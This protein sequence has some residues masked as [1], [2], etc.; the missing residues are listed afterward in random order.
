QPVAAIEQTSGLIVGIVRGGYTAQW[1]RRRVPAK[2]IKVYDSNAA[3][4]KAA[5]KGDIK[6]FV[7]TKISLLYYLRQN[8]LANIF[9]HQDDAPL[10]TQIYYAATRKTNAALIGPV[11][12]GLAAIGQEERKA[13]EAKWIVSKAKAISPELA[14]LLSDR[15]LAYLAG[16]EGLRVYN[17]NAWAPFNFNAE[18]TA[19]GF[20]IDYMQLLAEKSG[21]EISFVNG[22]GWQEALE[23]MRSDRLDVM[24]NMARDPQGEA[25][26]TFTAP[27][28]ELIPALYTRNDFPAVTS[29]EDLYGKRLAAA[30]GFFAHDMFEAHPQIEVVP[31]ADTV[32]AARAVSIGQADALVSFMPV[33]DAIIDRIQITNLKVGGDLGIGDGTPIPLRIAVRKT[34]DLLPAILDK[35]MALVSYQESDSLRE[36]WLQ[37]ADGAPREVRLRQEEQD[38]L[39]AHQAI[40][41]GVDPSWPPFELTDA[42]GVYA[43]I[44]SDYVALLNARL[45]TAMAPV[46][47]LSWSAVLAGVQNGSIDVIP[48]IARSPAREKYLL[49]TKPYLR[50]QS[51]IVTRKEAPFLSGLGDLSDREVGVIKGYVTQEIIERDYPDIRVKT[52]ANVEEGLRALAQDKV[53][54]FVDNLASITYT[55]KMMGLEEVRVAATTNYSYDLA[56]GVRKDWPELVPIL[57][58]GLAAIGKVERAKIHDRWV[59]VVIERAV[60]W[61]YVQR[62]VLIVVL[63]AGMLVGFILLWNRRLAHEIVE[64]KRAE[65]EIQN[66][67]RRQIQIINSLPDPTFVIDC[68]SRVIAWNRAMEEITGIPAADIMG[69]G[70]YEYAIPFYGDRR[71]ILIDLVRQW[72]ESTSRKYISISRDE[73]GTLTS[74]SFHPDLKGGIYLSG[75]ARVLLDRDNQPDG[76]IETLRDITPLKEMEMALRER[77]AYF[78]AV[79]AN[80]GVGIV[81][82]DRQGRFTR[83]NDTFL[84]FLGFAW[85]ELQERRL[86]DLVHPDYAAEFQETMDRIMD[87]RDEDTRLECRFVRKDQEWRWADVCFTPIH[88]EDGAFLAAVTTVTDITH[89]KRAEVE[90]ARRLRSEK[91]L[92]SISQALLSA[93]TDTEILKNALQQLVAAVQ[94]DRVYVYENIEDPAR[95]LCARLRFEVCAPGIASCLREASGAIWPYQE[96]MQRWQAALGRGEPIMGPVDRFPEEEQTRLAP[97]K[98]LSTLILPLQVHGRWFGFVGLDDTYLRRDWSTSDVALLGTTAEIIG[99]FLTRRSAEDEL[100]RAKEKAEEATRAKSEFLANMSHEIRTPMNAVIG[101]S[102][103]ALKTELTPK[104]QDYVQKI[105]NAGQSLL[106]IINDILDFSKIEAGKMDMEAVDF[107]LTATLEDVANMISLKA[108]ERDRL[109]VLFRID[110][111]VPENLVGDPLR[112]S[113]V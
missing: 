60:D 51:V 111:R 79:F 82:S 4:F 89:R 112:L 13:L 20:S 49:F 21:L 110:P 47:G 62:V 90:Q 61:E 96:G 64:R 1:V 83:V 109:E 107:S 70:D 80:A 41:L 3:L 76:A 103:L 23:M 87:G 17:Q 113:Q 27:Y 33:M 54:A 59:N 2:A 93:S 48:C 45:G 32:E 38:W 6:A 55:I 8:R 30:P 69:K 52:F 18:G 78:R 99:A 19:R 29:V 104:Q 68:D 101:L 86:I 102:H 24:L 28:I 10:F 72:D 31:V 97:Q 94:V 95:G 53:I 88:D 46:E 106:G 5:Y 25:Y 15:E 42:S 98:A 40:R 66:S 84:G 63:L 92:A 36:R 26:L 67:Q 22:P 100:L 16:N 108:Q 57:E 39:A 14:V 11:N 71:P 44:A 85:Q 34:L 75:A 73:E 105:A 9:A 65:N 7:A 56:F 58:K 77:E 37:T 50:F 35:A 43:G 91:A 12:I 81:S 74:M